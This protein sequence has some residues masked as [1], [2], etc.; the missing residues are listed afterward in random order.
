MVV[1]MRKHGYWGIWILAALPV[2][3]GGMY[4]AVLQPYYETEK[5]E[6][7]YFPCRRHCNRIRNFSDRIKSY[8][9]F[10][11]IRFCVKI[12]NQRKR[13]LLL[14]N[15]LKT[16]FREDFCFL[17]KVCFEYKKSVSII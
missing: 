16:D 10:D 1:K 12:L 2:Y 7:I 6:I 14:I 15:V 4:S 9:D 11:K 8:M 13:C 3:M 5:E 17:I